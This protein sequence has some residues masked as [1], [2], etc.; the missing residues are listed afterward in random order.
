MAL[1][2]KKMHQ[3]NRNIDLVH[4]KNR[5]LERKKLKKQNYLVHFYY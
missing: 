2:V 1:K 3:I 4:L 5:I